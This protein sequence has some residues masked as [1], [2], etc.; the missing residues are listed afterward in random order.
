MCARSDDFD[1]ALVGGGPAGLACAL[2]LKAADPALNV[3][4]FD[5]RKVA[6]QALDK[7]CGEGLMPDGAD[8]LRALGVDVDALR[9]RPFR[10]IRW[11]EDAGAEA[12]NV[13]PIE[14]AGRFPGPPG[15]GIRRTELHAALT[16]AAEERGVNL[17]W[18]W[19]VL[20]TFG[21]D[22]NR[23]GLR[24]ETPEGDEQRVQP[25]FVVAAD[26][27]RSPLRRELGLDGRSEKPS[28]S[29][30][31]VRRHFAI[32]PWTDCVEVHW[33]PNLE[34]YVTPVADDEV[35]VAFLWS[36]R[37]AGFDELLA[38][39]PKL[40]ERLGGAAERSRD[41]GTGPLRQRV[42]AVVKDNVAL[43][44]DAAGYVDAITGEGLSVALHQAHLL[45]RSI[46]EDD[47][48]IY[49]RECRRVDRIPRWLTELMLFLQRRPALRRRAFCALERDPALFDRFLAVHVR[50][51]SPSSLVPVSPRMAWRLLTAG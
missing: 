7:P 3:V 29:R 9:C 34:A 8:R 18:G 49:G 5:R 36:G 4:V 15:L 14:V 13:R 11:V 30:F 21:A 41:L 10:G 19:K 43:V 51:A 50:H 31:G 12:K 42:R 46:V 28:R 17:R 1:V 2:E 33:G 27:L 6:K 40:A 23:L 48:S 26:G 47:L 35:G 22:S 45:A 16:H 38:D 25:R 37:K 32:A 20:G 44:G 39:L 24:I